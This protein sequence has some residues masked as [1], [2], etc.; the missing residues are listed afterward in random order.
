MET[1]RIK[2]LA[3]IF[4]YYY[5]VVSW[6][7]AILHFDIIDTHARTIKVSSRW[8][9]L[10][11]SLSVWG[12]FRIRELKMWW[13]MSCTGRFIISDFYTGKCI[14]ILH[15][16]MHCGIALVN[17]Q[18]Y[19]INQCTVAINNAQGLLQWS[20]LCDIALVNAQW[21]WIDQCTVMLNWSMHSDIAL[22]IAQWYCNNQCTVIVQ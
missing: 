22:I 11:A 6:N 3:A 2:K 9:N 1:S 10:P 16:S 14:V 21:C 19:C 13:N 15:W 18:W 17:A 5:C 20:M 4:K 8:Y 12:K 7:T